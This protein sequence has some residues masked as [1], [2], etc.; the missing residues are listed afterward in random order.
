VQLSIDGIGHRYEYI[1]HPAN[2][3]VCE[4]NVDRYLEDYSIVDNLKLSI[5]H[6]LSAFN[7]FYLDEF[8]SWCKTKKLPRPWVGRVHTP[9]HFRIGVYPESIKHYIIDFLQTSDFDDVKSWARAL[10]NQNDSEWFETF[11][12]RTKDHDQYRGNSFSD[13]FAEL[14]KLIEDNE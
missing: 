6:T 10:E 9:S 7:I 1:R 8:F 5:S 14:A 12:T 2:W 11:K 13:S 3:K 4:Q